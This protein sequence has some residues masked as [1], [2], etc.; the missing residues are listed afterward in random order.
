VSTDES[1]GGAEAGT[2]AVALPLPLAPPAGDGVGAALPLHV[3]LA[4]LG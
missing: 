2:E 3:P 1:E 4:L